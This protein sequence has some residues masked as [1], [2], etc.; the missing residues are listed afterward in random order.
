MASWVER[1]TSGI[2][3]KAAETWKVPDVDVLTL[4]FGELHYVVLCR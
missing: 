3:Y 1:G 4:L 2:I